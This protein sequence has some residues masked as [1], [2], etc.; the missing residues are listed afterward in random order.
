MDIQRLGSTRQSQLDAVVA[1]PVRIVEG[2]RVDPHL[3]SEV[4][5][6]QE[7][8]KVRDAVFPG[9]E[10]EVSVPAG[11]TVAVDEGVA[12]SSTT[13]DDHPLARHE[14]EC[15][16]TSALSVVRSARESSER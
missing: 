4:L 3:A 5:L 1:I 10:N 16:W 6:G 15:P 13:D 7:R 14:S 11:L 8:S 2:E 12:G 9:D